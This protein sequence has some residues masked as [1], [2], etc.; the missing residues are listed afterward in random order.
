VEQEADEPG[1]EPEGL[2]VRLA[3]VPHP[4]SRH[5]RRYP[6]RVLL[7]IAVAA[8][9]S[10]AKTYTEVAEFAAELSQEQ[11]AALG[12]IK[13][14]WEARYQAPGEAA[15]RR[16]LQRLDVEVLDGLVGGWLA[17]QL[18]HGDASAVAVDG[19]CL[20]GAVGP[21]GRRVHLLAALVHDHGTVVA[22]RWVAAKSSEID[23]FAPL[24]DD[25]EL[26]GRVVTADSLHTQRAHARYLIEQR[27]AAYLLVVK[28]NQAGM[29]TAIDRL[30]EQAFSPSAPFR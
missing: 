14:S 18:P 27:K 30:S 5:G 20:R 6:L 7:G 21:D 29:V 24:L 23:A 11:L 16:A 8:V 17:E 1:G 25:V 4:R 9:L 3:R 22:Q 12:C 10:G 2:L 26:T 28:G 19:K 15:L 13:R